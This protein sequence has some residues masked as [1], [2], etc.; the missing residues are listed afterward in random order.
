M[1]YLANCGYTDGM[2]NQTNGTDTDS[3][4]RREDWVTTCPAVPSLRCRL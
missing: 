1:G 3:C 2:G 4:T